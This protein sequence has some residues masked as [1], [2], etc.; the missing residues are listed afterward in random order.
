MNSI[1]LNLMVFFGVSLIVAEVSHAHIPINPEEVMEIAIAKG[2][3]T[4]ISIDN[5]NIEDIY[6]Y[7]TDSANNRPLA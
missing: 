4:R 6:A 5:D 1:R 7:P 3:L 2:G